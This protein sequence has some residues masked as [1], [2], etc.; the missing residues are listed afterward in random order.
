M[1]L[2]KRSCKELLWRDLEGPGIPGDL[3]EL[4]YR[5]LS[6]GSCEEIL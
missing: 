3:R 5:D 6:R 1:G 4:L 2:V